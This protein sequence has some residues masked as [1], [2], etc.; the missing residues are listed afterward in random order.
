MHRTPHGVNGGQ[1]EQSP[2]K[3]RRR[4]GKALRVVREQLEPRHGATKHGSGCD[5]PK[6]TLDPGSAGMLGKPGIEKDVRLS[7]PE[8]AEQRIPE[9]PI[10]L[11]DL[12]LRPREAGVQLQNERGGLEDRPDPGLRQEIEGDALALEVCAQVEQYSAT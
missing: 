8:I 12:A 6:A 9:I 3:R 7:P 5:A 2:P 4:S 11:L 10:L 1:V